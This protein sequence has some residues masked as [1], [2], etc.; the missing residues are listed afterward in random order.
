MLYSGWGLGAPMRR[1]WRRMEHHAGWRAEQT[2]AGHVGPTSCIWSCAPK[3]TRS[4]GLRQHVGAQSEPHRPRTSLR[5]PPSQ[6]SPLPLT[7]QGWR[8]THVGGF[9]PFFQWVSSSW[10]P[11]SQSATVCGWS[12]HTPDRDSKSLLGARRQCQT[13]QSQGPLRIFWT[14]RELCRPK[15]DLESPRF[16]TSSSAYRFGCQNQFPWQSA[17]LVAP[18]PP[19][20]TCKFRGFD[21]IVVI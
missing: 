16:K 14:R 3:L 5:P 4:L 6:P 10:T 12:S 18:L 8:G 13:T 11:L 1:G 19:Q 7:P 15:P 9:G 20:K 2:K 21:A 17:H